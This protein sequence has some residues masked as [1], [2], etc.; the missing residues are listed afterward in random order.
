MLPGSKRGT[1]SHGTAPDE[2]SPLRPTP[3]EPAHPHEWPLSL[4]DP[5][6][7]EEVFGP[8]PSEPIFAVL[9]LLLAAR[10]LWSLVE[11]VG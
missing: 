1:P 9:L 6:Q 7:F 3:D 10:L 11:H 4:H 8:A 5:N 2:S